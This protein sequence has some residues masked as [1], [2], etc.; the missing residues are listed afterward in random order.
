[1]SQTPH[2]ASQ[3]DHGGITFRQLVEASHE[4]AILFERAKHALNDVA[5][6]VFWSIEQPWQTGFGSALDRT[7]RDDRL[8][9]V[10]VA[11]STQSFGVITLVGQQPSAAFAGTTANV[12]NVS[13][14]P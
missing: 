12:R 10:A 3:R 6:P 7:Q 8:H 9:S 13:L 2:S 14:I 11:V 5:L 4:P 1:M